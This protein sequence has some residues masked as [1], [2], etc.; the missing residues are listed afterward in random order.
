M[1]NKPLI[2]PTALPPGFVDPSYD[3]SPT[4]ADPSARGP[5][6]AVLSSAVSQDGPDSGA[7]GVLVPGSS[8]TSTPA[9]RISFDDPMAHSDQD[10]TV[11]YEGA[12]S[13]V[14][15]IAANLTNDPAYTTLTF[16]AT[17]ANFC[18][19]GI[20][21]WSIG[22][23]RAKQL[24]ST[25][26]SLNLPTSGVLPPGASPTL[27]QWTADYV[28]ITDDLAVQGDP[29]W[30]EPSSKNDCWD[31]ALADTPQT[32]MMDSAGNPYS[33]LG[34]N[35]YN[36][37]EAQFDDSANAD[38]H[39]ARDFPILEAHNGSLVVGRFGWNPSVTEQTTNRVIVGP[40]PSN[41]P[42]LRFAQ[43]CFHKQAGFKVRAGGE[44][45]ANGSNVGLLHHVIQSPTSDRCV[46]SCDPQFALLNARS[47]DVPWGNPAK[48][49]T[50]PA[51]L[52]VSQLGRDSV[53]AMRNPMFSFITWTGCGPAPG[54]G[55]HTLT[56][57]DYTWKFSMRGGFDPV[58]ISLTQGTNTFVSPQSML[59]INPLGQLAVVDGAQQGLV[60]IDLNTL[61]FAHT[62][63]Y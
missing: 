51:S 36:A 32:L 61:A 23:Q 34:N 45:V 56:A 21:D 57:R 40:D 60:I 4:Q 18:S 35:R 43:C 20:E 48:G 29:Y 33:T 31:D 12:L 63:Y 41:R 52:D 2:L 55:D 7:L 15:G 1:Q 10:W 42:F 54:T 30:S 8:T 13:S 49:C 50:P 9:V 3:Q 16:E 38:T 11:G 26:A 25:L 59:F 58:Q 44:W 14:G 22:Q 27:D 5:T 46:L 17:G 28:E 19:R 47:F 6:S 24:L 39:L 37:C 53:L 62:P